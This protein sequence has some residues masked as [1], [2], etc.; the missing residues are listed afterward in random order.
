MK[1][2][3]EINICIL[4]SS[5]LFSQGLAEILKNKWN[6]SIVHA[7]NENALFLLL[8]K[9]S[10]DI[11]IYDLFSTS[12]SFETAMKTILGKSS[13][14]KVVVLSFETNEDLIEMCIQNGASGFF[15]KN[16]ADNDLIFDTIK[17]IVKGEVSIL[18]SQVV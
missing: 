15:D 3:S 6:V 16:I 10:P 13:Q 17:K 5:K 9:S 4:D 8:E 11:I 18:T 2:E 1:K 7:A 14:S 12:L